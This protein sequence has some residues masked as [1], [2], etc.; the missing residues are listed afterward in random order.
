MASSSF[1]FPRGGL[2]IC[3]NTALPC[4]LG[5]I[6]SIFSNARS[7]KLTPL[8]ISVSSTPSN[9]DFPSNLCRSSATIRSFSGN[10]STDCNWPIWIPMGMILIPTV[11]PKYSNP[12]YPRFDWYSRPSILLQQERKC[13]A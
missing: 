6:L 8:K 9:T 11:R 5:C 12:M 13:L 10:R 4:H 3:T 2:A 1:P 7:F